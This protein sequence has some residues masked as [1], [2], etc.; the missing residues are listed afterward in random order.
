MSHEP[1]SARPL[2]T[3]MRVTCTQC[4]YNLTG[5]TI[6]SS[7]PEC[8]LLVGQGTLAASQYLPMSGKAIASLV[9]GILSIVTCSAYGILSVP[10]GI[11]AIYLSWG[12]KDQ[13]VRQEVSPSSAG[14][15]KAG[16]VCGI[17]GLC[18]GSTFILVILLFFVLAAIAS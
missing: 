11:I 8:G 5:V 15:A 2:P 4:G 17:V 18:L 13:I 7:C 10:C 12:V 6:G 1:S 16:K 14:L 3:E 9:M